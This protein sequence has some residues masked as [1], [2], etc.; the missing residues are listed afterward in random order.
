M[1]ALFNSSERVR[2]EHL[3]VPPSEPWR[4]AGRRQRRGGEESSGVR[5]SGQSSGD[6]TD[7]L[8]KSLHNVTFLTLRVGLL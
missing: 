6:G 2:P 7:L 8:N 4:L 3:R 5:R 1:T